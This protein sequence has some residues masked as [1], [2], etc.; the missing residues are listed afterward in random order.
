MVKHYFKKELWKYTSN[1]ITVNEATG[2]SGINKIAREDIDK[3]C[4]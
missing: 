1:K 4:M 3:V 2:F